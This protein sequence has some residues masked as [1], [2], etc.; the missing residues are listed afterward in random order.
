MPHTSVL[1]RQNHAT[2]EE[3]YDDKELARF[4]NDITVTS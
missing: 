2:Q 1:I 4:D 3:W